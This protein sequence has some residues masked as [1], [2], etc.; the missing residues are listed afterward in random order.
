VM[1]IA[2][3]LLS[4]VVRSIR[5]AKYLIEILDILEGNDRVLLI[6]LRK[7]RLFSMII[8][9]FVTILAKSKIILQKSTY[10]S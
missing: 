2:G 5:K 9:G 3:F 1:L 7:Y 10:I 8:G 4:A 6:L